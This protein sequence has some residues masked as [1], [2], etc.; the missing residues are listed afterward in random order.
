MSVE[1]TSTSQPPTPTAKEPSVVY[2]LI[3][4]G[5]HHKASLF[6]K[7][8]AAADKFERHVQ[9]PDLWYLNLTVDDIPCIIE[10]TD[11]GMEHTGARE[12]SIRKA[13]AAILCYSSMS[14][15]S[16]HQLSSVAED[17]KA[18]KGFKYPPIKLICNEDDVVEEDFHETASFHTDQSLSEGYESGEESAQL[19]SKNSVLKRRPSMEKIREAHESTRITSDQGETMTKLFGPDCEFVSMSVAEFA[20]ARQ[21]LEDLIRTINEKNHAKLKPLLKNRRKS[22]EAISS[23]SAKVSPTNSIHSDSVSSEGSESGATGTKGG[24][25][26]S[27]AQKLKKKVGNVSHVCTIS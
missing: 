4:L 27:N 13:E 9:Y 15:S 21:L 25:R 19:R 14:A 24:R 7:L 11:P 5:S 2:N 16:F 1:S 18:R 12:M 20:G 17:F 23:S 26:M 22:K 3:F 10:L 8:C 6:D